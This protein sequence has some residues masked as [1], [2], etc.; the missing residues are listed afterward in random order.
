MSFL[1]ITKF[2]FISINL[3]RLDH[4]LLNWNLNLNIWNEQFLPSLY[5][6]LLVRVCIVSYVYH[7]NWISKQVDE[8]E[9]SSHRKRW[10]VDL[11]LYNLCVLAICYL[12]TI[13][14][15]DIQCFSC[16]HL[17]PNIGLKYI[18]KISNSLQLSDAQNILHQILTILPYNS[19]LFFFF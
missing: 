14:A 4:K 17:A 1:Y 16:I 6:C 8:T 10:G 2:S 15:N 18:W 7:C 12:L 13:L 3:A 11:G 5:V 9:L 19:L